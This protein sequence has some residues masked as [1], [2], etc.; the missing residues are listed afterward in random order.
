[1]PFGEQDLDYLE[2]VHPG[3]D[4]VASEML[5]VGRAEGI[6]IVQLPVAR[7]LHVMVAAVRPA[8]VVEVGTAI[9]FSTLW[10]AT[11]LPP[12]GR[13]DTIDPDRS[14]TDRARRFWIRAQVGDRIRVINEPALRVLPRLAA[15]ID[16]AFIDAIKTEYS[17]YLEALLPKMRPGGVILADNLL[18]SGRIAAGDHDADTDAL[19]AFNETFLHHPQLESTVLPISDGLGFGAVR[20]DEEERSHPD[21]RSPY[22]RPG[23]QRSSS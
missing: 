12:D 22:R 15:G 23:S 17:A 20:P 4:A 5:A 2:K 7:F 14:R 21:E 19:R 13:I 3:L 11:A 18:W 1:M 10:M 6:P 16:L 8:R 9:G